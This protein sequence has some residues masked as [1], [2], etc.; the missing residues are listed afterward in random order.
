MIAEMDQTAEATAPKLLKS[1]KEIASA[2]CMRIDSYTNQSQKIRQRWAIHR[3]LYLCDPSVVHMKAVEGMPPYPTSVFRQKISRLAG[4]LAAGFLNASPIVQVLDEGNELN[5]DEMIE[6]SLEAISKRGGRQRAIEQTCLNAALYN[7]GVLRITPTTRQWLDS[8]IVGGVEWEAIDPHQFVIY[9][10]TAPVVASASLVGTAFYLSVDEINERIKDG[11]F[12]DVTGKVSGGDD[13][14]KLY[15]NAQ[16]IVIRD[17]PVYAGDGEALCYDVLWR[18]NLNGELRWWHIK[19]L[20]TSTELLYI[21]PYDS[22]RPDLVVMRLSSLE[23]RV[24]TEDSAAL[25]I[26]GLCLLANDLLTTFAQGTLTSAIPMTWLTGA[27]GQTVENYRP[28]SINQLPDGA[29]ITSQTVPFNGTYLV[30]LFELVER[31]IDSTIGLSRLATGQGL[32]PSSTA[33][34]A[35]ALM[36]SDTQAADINASVASGAI[37]EAFELTYEY[38]CRYFYDLKTRFG[39]LIPMEDQSFMKNHYE[40]EVTGSSTAANPTILMA[41]L[42]QDMNLALANPNSPVDPAKL[43]IKMLASQN[44]PFNSRTILKDSETELRQLMQMFSAEGLG[45]QE[46]VQLGTAYLEERHQAVAHGIQLGLTDES[47]MEGQP[48]Q[49]PAPVMGGQLG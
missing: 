11:E 42:Q 35:N 36:A 14:N 31:L 4:S 45:A 8:K 32:A 22:S 13:P 19:V 28:G 3:K 41:K 38:L 1:N 5:N 49:T 29:Q 44:L 37:K 43:A 47:Q 6:Q 27:M 10:P 34:E 26:Q 15:Q 12:L 48:P 39:S 9:P 40:F 16:D 21:E 2:V 33:T 7:V 30:T 17:A 24:I 46:L 25:G 18:A 23:D 20:H